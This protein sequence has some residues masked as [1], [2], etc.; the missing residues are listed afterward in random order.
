MDDVSMRVAPPVKVLN[1]G[2]SWS[3]PRVRDPSQADWWSARI[4]LLAANDWLD[5]DIAAASSSYSGRRDSDV[6]QGCATARPAAQH[7]RYIV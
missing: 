7:F 4:F 5:K 3:K 1:S 2:K 6:T